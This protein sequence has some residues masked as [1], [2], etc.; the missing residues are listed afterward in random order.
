MFMWRH[1]IKVVI[2]QID[3]SFESTDRQISL[4]YANDITVG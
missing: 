4:Q 3:F 2:E 1:C